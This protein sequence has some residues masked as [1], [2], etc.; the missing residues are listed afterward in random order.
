MGQRFDLRDARVLL[1][2]AT[3]GLGHAMARSLAGRGARLLLTGRR[4]DVL[5]PL[6]DEV[7]ADA[8]AADLSDLDD[9][10]RLLDEAGDVDVLVANA[11]VPATGALPE[12]TPEQ[13]DRAVRVNLLVPMLM[14]RELVGPMQVRG[15]GHIVLVGSVSGIT[16]S[17]YASVYNGT[18]FGLRGFGLG[19][20]QEL[21]G[22]GVGVSVV[23]PGFVRDAGMFAEGGGKLPLGVRSV[24]PDQVGAAVVR[25]IERNLGE[26]VVAPPEL[27]ALA[28]TGSLLPGVSA[29]VQRMIGAQEIAADLAEGQRDKR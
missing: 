8:A 28:R 15:R 16:A 29:R 26:V 20:R 19:L 5:E 9:V 17:S 12:F 18:K 22:S 11:A 25:A 1:T 7:D 6:A 27:R 3:G 24:G 13:L 4:T 14:A 21:H 2:G 23:E 10:R